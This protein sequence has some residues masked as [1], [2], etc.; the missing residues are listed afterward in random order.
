[1]DEK[2]KNA[3]DQP[4]LGHIARLVAEEHKLYEQSA[5]GRRTVH[6]WR[7]SRWSSINAGTSC[8]SVGPDANS[9]KIQRERTYAH[10]KS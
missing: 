7:E 10:R 5:L 3:T 8:A 2:T 9:A 4:V 6:G 1:M